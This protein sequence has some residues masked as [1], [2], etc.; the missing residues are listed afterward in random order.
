MQQIKPVLQQPQQSPLGPQ[1]KQQIHHHQNLDQDDDQ[2]NYGHTG[3]AAG[4]GIFGS[5]SPRSR[6]SGKRLSARTSAPPPP[7]QPLPPPPNAS[8]QHGRGYAPPDPENDIM[9]P[10]SVLAE[11]L[12]LQ[13]SQ[14]NHFLDYLAASGL[15]ELGC[16][17]AFFGV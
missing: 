2:D 13:R 5:C 3:P 10:S 9:D 15:L 11:A 1:L 4:I 14:L 6:A 17:K 16:C 8:L 12:A 7:A